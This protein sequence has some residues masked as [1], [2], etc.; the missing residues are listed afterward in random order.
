MS[1]RRKISGTPDEGGWQVNAAGIIYRHRKVQPIIYAIAKSP[2]VDLGPG[3]SGPVLTHGHCLNCP[4]CA[5][6]RNP[7][8]WRA[9]RPERCPPSH[10]RST[11]RLLDE[12]V[13]Y[14][15]AGAPPNG[16]AASYAHHLDRGVDNCCIENLVW[17]ADGA[18]LDERDFR[19]V[20]GWMKPAHRRP[21]KLG[22]RNTGNYSAAQPIFTG[23]SSVPGHIPTSPERIGA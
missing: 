10:Q 7:P 13:L 21:P 16:W 8:K 18:Y 20:A 22:A 3:Y 17:M 5:W 9:D 2:S 14:E 12:I 1:P 11:L 6:E 4:G 23:S 15:F 19:V